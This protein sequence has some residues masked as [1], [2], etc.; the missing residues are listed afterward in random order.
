MIQSKE[1]QWDVP[2]GCSSPSPFDLGEGGK[3]NCYPRIVDPP[4]GS[5]NISDPGVWPK[6][7][8]IKA[9]K[10]SQSVSDAD[11]DIYHLSPR[12]RVRRYIY[13]CRVCVTVR[14]YTKVPFPA[15]YG[16]SVRKPSKLSVGLVEGHEKKISNWQKMKI[17]FY[18]NIRI[19]WFY[20]TPMAFPLFF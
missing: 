15:K 19:C 6:T 11:L 13:A 1:N 10:L 9:S 2:A 4:R 20:R 5:P 16:V 8:T 14:L 18:E 12:I 17:W 3:G 7:E